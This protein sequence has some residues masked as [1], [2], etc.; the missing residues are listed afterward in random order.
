MPPAL[1]LLCGAG[2]VLGDLPWTEAE[3]RL[4]PERVVV[5]PL[6]AGAKEHGPHLPLRNDQLL[7]EELARRIVAA[8]P[9]V[10]L[11]TLAYGYYP[12]FLEYPGSVSLS[13]E[14]QRDVLVQICRSLARYGPRRFYVL[15]TGI[16]TV[17]PLR[18]ASELLAREGVL[19]RFS[20][21]RVVGRA[22]ED[23]VRKQSH[24][25]H[26]DEIETSMTLHVAPQVVDMSKAVSDGGRPHPG[27]LTRDAGNPEGHYSPSGVFGDATLAT[28]EKGERVFSAALADILAE[29][30]ALAAAPPP[31][32]QP[33]SPLTR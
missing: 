15:N 33:L 17:N 29:I 21:P 30:D 10:L 6:G 16:S 28:R 8:R 11:P 23:A 2:V 13:F 14:T 19:L 3:Q 1:A 20:D 9:V 24:G 26:A 32:G 7:A 5:L 22:A 25:S 18:A 12:A 4:T 27:P 31:P